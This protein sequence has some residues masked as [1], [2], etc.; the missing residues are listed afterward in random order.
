[1]STLLRVM[2]HSG[3]KHRQSR[4]T[5]TLNFMF[6]GNPGTG[7]THSARLVGKILFQAGIR[8]DIF[9]ETSGRRLL[10][11]STS[12]SKIVIDS[13][14]GGVL[15]IDEVISLEISRF[16]VILIFDRRIC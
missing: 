14:D 15:F 12:E 3:S 2:K 8:Q 1:M 10:Q 5:V 16:H 11:M 6:I 4:N 7:K 13:A 9:I